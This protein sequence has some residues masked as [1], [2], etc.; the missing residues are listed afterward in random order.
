MGLVE[1]QR[2]VEAREERARGRTVVM[3]E[4]R[5]MIF[6]VIFVKSIFISY[7]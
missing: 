1:A 2:K 6:I 4:M 5:M 3:E 7:L